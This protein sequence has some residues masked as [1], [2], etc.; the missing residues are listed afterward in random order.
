MI[1]D[2]NCEHKKFP[3]ADALAL[4]RVAS[5]CFFSLHRFRM[6]EGTSLLWTSCIKLDIV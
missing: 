3:E 2:R 4:V 1:L 6:P 5:A